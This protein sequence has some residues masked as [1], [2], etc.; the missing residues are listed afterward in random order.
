M[1]PISSS[2]IGLEISSPIPARS[3]SGYPDLARFLKGK[4]LT[5]KNIFT[6]SLK[7]ILYV[8]VIYKLY[9]LNY[10]SSEL[11]LFL[12]NLFSKISMNK[13]KE[14]KTENELIFD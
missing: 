1:G 12:Q 9:N 13:N 7:A 8:Y 5:S 10:N 14:H 11:H 2:P 4:F 6:H 3:G